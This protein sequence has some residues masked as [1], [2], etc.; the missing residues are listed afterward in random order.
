M[1]ANVS[2]VI[3]QLQQFLHGPVGPTG[4]LQISDLVIHR[5]EVKLCYLISPANFSFRS[6]RRAAAVSGPSLLPKCG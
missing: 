5:F 3:S 1:E 2:G 4:K 6:V